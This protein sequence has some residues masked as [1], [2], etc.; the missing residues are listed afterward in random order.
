MKDKKFL[1]AAGIS[2]LLFFFLGINSYSYL[3]VSGVK[4]TLG[5]VIVSQTNDIDMIAFGL[6]FP[7]SIL[8]G[9]LEKKIKYRISKF[10]S[11][12]TSFVISIL[13]LVVFLIANAL[14]Y[15]MLTSS[16]SLFKRQATV[17]TT[18]YNYTTSVF[19]G[20]CLLI[21]LRFSFLGCVFMGLKN[22]LG[23]SVSFVALALIN[24]FDRFLII[25]ASTVSPP[26][27]C[28]GSY[29]LY[30][31]VFTSY[32]DYHPNYWIYL[33]FWIAVFGIVFL[34]NHFTKG[35]NL[36]KKN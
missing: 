31:Y 27:I 24:Y 3:S 10:E 6:F 22:F 4:P 17:L 33:C 5:E 7:Y 34:F 15:I 23:N 20:S 19:G 2:F 35:L 13:T 11:I 29:S 32:S 12:Q 30:D 14:G 25:V 21:I 9:Q 16:L 8:L 36:C 1:V 18:Y 28:L 26:I